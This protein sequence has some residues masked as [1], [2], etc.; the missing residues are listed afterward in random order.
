MTGIGDWSIQ[1]QK[2]SPRVRPD[3]SAVNV[4]SLHGVV[5]K[6]IAN[7]LATNGYLTEVWRPDWRL[8]AH[9]AGHV[10]QR[11][12]EGGTASAWNAHAHATDGIFCGVG[13]AR[14]ALYDGRRSSPTFGAS[15]GF[16][17][18]AERPAIVVVPPGIWHAI[19]NIGHT[20]CVV[21][22]VVDRAYDYDDPDV[23][24]LP[25]DTPLIPFAG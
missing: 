23:F 8:D 16:C 6:E 13:R 21:I 2:D 7:V 14:V 1:G 19:R 11:V 5:V 18:G 15:V 22:N 24:R 4:P 20:P 12:Y 3:W 25:L 9:S 17:I 10:I